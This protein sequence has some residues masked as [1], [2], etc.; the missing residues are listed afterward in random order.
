QPEVK[1]FGELLTDALKETNALEK[2]SDALNAA[3]AAGEID[4]VS[5]VVIASQ[6]ADIAL[7]L[8]LQV[9][10]RAISAYQELMRMQV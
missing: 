8:T 1:T 6:K 2:K 5:Q 3:L 10:N 9:R 4:D 7:N